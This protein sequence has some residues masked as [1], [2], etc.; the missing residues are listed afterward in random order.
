MTKINDIQQV[1]VENH[2]TKT[3]IDGHREQ[4]IKGLTAP[5]KYI[6]SKFLYDG[7]GSEL[8]EMITHLPEYYPPKLEIKLLK[9]TG[10]QLAEKLKDID[11]VELG[12]GDCSKIS[13]LLES[14]PPN[15][16]KNICYL[17]FD[18][19][20]QAVEKSSNILSD[21]FPAIHIK[22]MVADFHT[23]LDIIPKRK[24]RLFCFFGSTLG[25]FSRQEA[26]K[27]IAR[28]SNTMQKDDMLLL[29]LDMVKDKSILEK[30]YNDNNNITAQFNLNILNVINNL[31]ETNFDPVDFEHIAFYNE[32]YSRIEMHIKAKKAMAV[33]SPFLNQPFSLQKAET[34]HTENSHKFTNEM[35]GDLALQANLKIQNTI[36]DSNNWF[37]IV[38]MA[39]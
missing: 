15:L 8:F 23:Q 38:Q 35:I 39:K 1:A 11:I 6:S 10:I 27:F 33:A 34:I 26:K 21:K 32:T 2:F 36:T 13:V 28:L 25:N 9:N 12:S 14:I 7:R 4:I 22:G 29:G 3:E 18:I 19:S 16:R 24:N 17:P 37:S 30:A 20:Q 31:L 5:V